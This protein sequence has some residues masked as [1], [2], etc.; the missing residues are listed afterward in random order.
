[1]P[2]IGIKD[3][4]ARLSIYP[5]RITGSF[6]SAMER[7]TDVLLKEQD[8]DKLH[9]Q[10]YNGNIQAYLIKMNNLNVFF[11]LQGLLQK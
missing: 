3:K 7:Y 5:T 4:A 11:D 1:M 8:L 2:K 6:A 10:V 9:N